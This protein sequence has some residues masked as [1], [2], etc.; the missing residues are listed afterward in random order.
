MSYLLAVV[1]G[2]LKLFSIFI[3]AWKII[4]AFFEN[5]YKILPLTGSNILCDFRMY[6]NMFLC[7]LGGSKVPPCQFSRQSEHVLSNRK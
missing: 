3:C 6:L 2:H 7:C 1:K 4:L 5:I